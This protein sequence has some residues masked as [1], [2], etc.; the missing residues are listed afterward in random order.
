MTR[1][2][3]AFLLA[4]S[5]FL[6]VRINALNYRPQLPRGSIFKSIGP[7]LDTEERAFLSSNRILAEQNEI[8]MKRAVRW[9]TT[10]LKFESLTIDDTIRQSSIKH[11]LLNCFLPSGELT[12]DYYKYTAWRLAQRFVSATSSVFGTQAL[13]LAL[14]FKQNRIGDCNIFTILP[15]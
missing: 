5:S 14:G 2:R 13:L 8:G 4:I 1:L 9:D 10:G 11:F 6:F 15:R 7:N 12:Q 3:Y